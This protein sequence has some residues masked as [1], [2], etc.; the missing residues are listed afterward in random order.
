MKN[1]MSLKSSLL[2]LIIL[3]GFF[4][5][6]ATA[7]AKDGY[8]K[9]KDA[10]L[11]DFAGVINKE[12]KKEILKLFTNLEQRTKIQTIIVT[13]KS[14]KDYKTK[15]RNI[16][17]F[18]TNLFNKWESGNKKKNK[19]ILLLLSLKPR[20]FLVKFGKEHSSKLNR[21][22]KQFIK[23]SVN[24]V[25][26]RKQYSK[27]IKICANEIA[28][29]FPPPKTSM[30]SFDS[31]YK[32]HKVHIFVGIFILV[33]ILAGLNCIKVGK[34]GWGWVFFTGVGMVLIALLTPRRHRR[35]GGGSYGSW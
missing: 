6:I 19:G 3:F 21:E 1:S 26:K 2:Y 7:Q 17:N 12:D 11:N 28:S 22:I 10:Y 32:T 15:D 23:S 4:L 27:A 31:W 14:Y 24:H 18:A 25:L 16:A 35:Y 20:I 29:K 33:S 34:G 30:E 13:M 5:S 8:P 9:Q